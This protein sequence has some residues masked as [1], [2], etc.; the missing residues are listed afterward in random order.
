MQICTLRVWIHL[1]ESCQQLY[2]PRT[3]IKPRYL[4][5]NPHSI[6]TTIVVLVTSVYRSWCA[7]LPLGGA[8]VYKNIT[9]HAQPRNVHIS[10]HKCTEYRCSN[11]WYWRWWY[12][13]QLG[14]AV[15]T[16]ASDV[17]T[18]TNVQELTPPSEP[19]LLSTDA[20]QLLNYTRR[21]S[22]YGSGVFSLSQS[23]CSV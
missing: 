5:D 16:R 20:C 22:V 3:P 13:E 2:L 15:L 10:Y 14:A 17:L 18:I 21:F 19:S 4:V 8:A 7:I 12:G 11:I 23:I 1:S 9:H 6:I